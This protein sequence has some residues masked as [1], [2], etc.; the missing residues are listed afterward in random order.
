[1]KRIS[2]LATMCLF[3]LTL[4]CAGTGVKAGD[5]LCTTAFQKT[6]DSVCGHEALGKINTY[7][8]CPIQGPGAKAP[9]DICVGGCPTPPPPPPP[10]PPCPTCP[11]CPPPVV[12]P[13]CPV[14][15]IFP[16]IPD[17]NVY[18]D[19]NKSDIH[20]VNDAKPNNNEATLDKVADTLKGKD[21]GWLG[22]VIASR[23]DV[24][25]SVE[26]NRKLGDRRATSVKDYLEKR[27]VSASRIKIINTGKEDPICGETTKECLQINRS[28]A[29]YWFKAN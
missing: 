18:F 13:V 25:G 28:A 24:R 16:D 9:T 2:A 5:N 21:N 17:M 15:K 1:M 29:I 7:E 12:C 23:C 20:T 4:G 22:I 8:A 3:L 19:T 6:D 27:G 14:C 11:T 26:L 10:T